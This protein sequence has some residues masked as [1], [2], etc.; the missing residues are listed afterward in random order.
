MLGARAPAHDWLGR[1]FIFLAATGENIGIGKD[2]L[3]GTPCH[4]HF[5]TIAVG[6]VAQ[7]QKRGSIARG[8]WRALGL[9]QLAGAGL[10]G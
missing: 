6:A 1:I 9:K 7:Q 8:N 2:A 4:Q 10:A 5:K 3:I